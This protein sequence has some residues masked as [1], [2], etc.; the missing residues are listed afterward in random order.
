[1]HYRPLGTTGI[2]ISAVSFGAGPVSSLLTG[3]E[4]DR[5]VATVRRA[6]ESGINWF[7]TAPTYGEGRSEAS[8]G[9]ALAELGADEVHVATKVRLPEPV[10][11]DIRGFVLQ[12]FAASLARLRR[13]R[14]TLLQV[15]NSITPRPGDLPTSITVEDV[16]GAGGLAEAFGELQRQGQVA[17]LGLTGLGDVP[18]LIEVMRSRIF[19][20]IQTP[21]HVLNP[22]A[23]TA[24]APA[25]I[26][27]NYGNLAAEAARL[28]MAFLAIRV[29]AGGALT[30]QPPSAHTKVTKF[31]P[32]STFESDQRRAAALAKQ[33]PPGLDLKELA[34]RYVL[35]IPSVC[36]AIVGLGSPEQV[37]EAVRWA[38]RGPLDPELVIQ[39]E[40]WVRHCG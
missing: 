13:R 21:L 18:S 8:L 36:S 12:S 22:S 7:D 30:G 26:E 37:G 34:L 25:G 16:L 31:F 9:M 40:R 35:S 14:V 3:S 28:G 6:I 19:A 33:L 17:H 29:F 11:R 32:L 4:V 1:M 39:I 27:A 10:P 38:D 23:A 2:S 20:S 5:Q 15:H 24:L